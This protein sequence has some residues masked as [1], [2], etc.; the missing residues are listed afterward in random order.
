M[1]VVTALSGSG[2]AYVFRLIE[3]LAAAGARAGLPPE[4]ASELAAATVF[5]AATLVHETGDSPEVLRERV[6]SPG[7]TTAAGLRALA[8]RGFHEALAAAVEQAT[9]RGRE[10]GEEAS[11]RLARR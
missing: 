9:A 10:L 7:G 3:A 1:D 5:G 11:K 8:E 6:T 2:P 4:V